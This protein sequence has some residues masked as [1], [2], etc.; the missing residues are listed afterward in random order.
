MRQLLMVTA[1]GLLM[2]QGAFA[3]T[4]P[5]S[6][7]PYDKSPWWM[8][9]SV[10]T[11]TGFVFAEVPA[12]RA[13]FSANFL[14]VDDTVEKAQAQSIEKTRAL[15]EV[16]GR[17]G[18]DQVRVTTSFSMRTLYEQYRDKD[19]NRI[20]NQRADKINGYEVSVQISVEVR[21]MNLLERAYALVLAASPTSTAN[22]Y[23]N[24]QPSNELNTW[25]Y[26]EAVK[27]ARKRAGDA[28]TAAGGTLGKVRVID[29]TGRA[30]E[31]DILARGGNGAGDD[32]EATEVMARGNFAYA[33]APPPPPPAPA[34]APAPGTADYLEAQALKNPFIQTP[35]LRRIDA[36][37][38]VVYAVN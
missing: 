23:F 8:K 26:N 30:C 18:K 14:S 1:A 29:P 4:A 35:P 9:E 32:T 11:Q 12:N 5:A 7:Y 21:D 38:C 17:L 28:V 19:G 25:M 37:A 10:I 13:T 36:R 24:L 34:M 2:A 22:I 15:Q 27:D 33:V 6:A 3:Q 20:E 31:T 16:L